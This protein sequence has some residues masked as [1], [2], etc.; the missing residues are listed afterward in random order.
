MLRKT[1][2]QEFNTSSNFKPP[3]P[4]KAWRIRN[5][6]PRSTDKPPIEDK[7]W[8]GVDFKTEPE[9]YCNILKEYF[10]K[11]NT[12]TDFVVQKNKVT[13]PERVVFGEST[14]GFSC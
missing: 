7:P 12:E 4:E 9:K 2:E 14:D 13:F 10:F 6:Y 1:A 11:G 3:Y 8:L 5:D